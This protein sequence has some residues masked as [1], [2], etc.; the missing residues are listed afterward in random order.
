MKIAVEVS[1]VLTTTV[2]T[3]AKRIHVDQT[4]CVLF[5]TKELV[6]HAR[7]QW[8]QVQPPKLVVFDPQLFH[9]QKTVIVLKVLLVSMTSVDQFV[10]TTKTA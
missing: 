9:A 1:H 8:C 10:L 7:Q 5:P 3:H 2:R 4:L 6:A